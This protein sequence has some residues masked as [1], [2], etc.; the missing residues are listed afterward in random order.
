MNIF[1]EK[2]FKVRMALAVNNTIIHALDLW[3]ASLPKGDNM[4][5]VVSHQR[6][7]AVFAF[8]KA[9]WE[10][11]YRSTQDTKHPWVAITEESLVPVEAPSAPARLSLAAPAEVPSAPGQPT[12]TAVA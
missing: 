10:M 7:E 11:G 12:L 4:R 5:Y 1:N 6:G 9:L 8:K 3:L 2:L